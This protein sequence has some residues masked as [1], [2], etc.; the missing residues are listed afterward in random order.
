[1]IVA[2]WDNNKVNQTQEKLFCAST[3]YGNVICR[4]VIHLEATAL[5]CVWLEKMF[6]SVVGTANNHH[7]NFSF[8]NQ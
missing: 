6:A 7:V 2:K 5:K 4:G 8:D 1:M 3:N